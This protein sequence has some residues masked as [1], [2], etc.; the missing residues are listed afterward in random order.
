MERDRA[1]RP[2]RCAR[3]RRG[4]GKERRMPS[5]KGNLLCGWGTALLL[6]F[7]G[8]SAF[9]FMPVDQHQQLHIP[10]PGTERAPQWRTAQMD[11]V[12]HPEAAGFLSRADG[13][14]W[15]QTNAVTG[16]PH[17]VFGSGLDLG[18]GFLSDE[19]AVEDVARAFVA[20]HAAYLGVDPAELRVRSIAHGLGKWG[21]VFDQIH[22]GVEVEGSRLRVL[23]TDEGR[24][25]YFGSDWHPGV[26]VSVQPGLGY[27]VARDLAA[28]P[29]G[30]Q[31]GRDVDE[32]GELRILPVLEE[33]S[34]VYRLVW[35]TRLEIA[36]P[37]AI[38]VSYVDAETGEILWRYNDVHYVDV[39]GTTAGDVEDFG[40]CYSE[41]DRVLPHMEVE[42][43][44]G[45]SG[46]SDENGLFDIPHG[47][48]DDVTV[49]AA[50]DGR[51]INANNQGGADASFSGIA[52][53][54]V[55]F[56]IRFDDGNSQDDERDVYLHGNRIHDLIKHYD[57]DWSP[58]DYRMS[59]NVSINSSCNA[60]WNGSSINFYQAGGGCGNTGQMGDVIYHEYGHGMTQWIYGNNP[61]DVG[62]GNSDIAAIFIDGNSIIGEGFYL[63][64]CSSGIRDADNNLQY[65]DDYQQGQIHFNGQIVAGFWWDAREILLPELGEQGTL[66]LLWPNWHFG[67]RTLQ[68]VSMPDQVL[69]AFLMDDDNGDLTDGTPHYDAFCPA[70]ENH[71]FDPPGPTPVVSIEHQALHNQ[72]DDGQPDVV[73]AT[74]TSSET[75]IDPAAIDLRYQV[76][77]GGIQVVP[78]TPTG[79]PDEYA[80]EIPA[81]PVGSF[82]D[83]SI[84][85]RD[86]DGN[87]G[88]YPP[89]NCDPEEPNGAVRFYV[90]T[91]VDEVES[92]LG[93]VV[94]PDGDD[95]ATTGIWERIDPRGT[96]AQPEDDQTP[97][98]GIYAWIT[99]QC[100]PGCGL[101]DNDI[102]GGKTTLLS[103]LYDLSGA[104]TA[105][106]VY[107]RWYS[108]DTG[109]EPGQD[110]W[111]VDVSNDGGETFTT[112]ENTNE[113]A[114]RWEPV[115]IDLNA[116]FGEPGSV[117]VRYTASDYEPGS[118]VEAGVDEFLLFVDYV[119]DAEEA[120]AEST[121]PLFALRPARPNPTD[122]GSRI[123]F[124][125]PSAAPVR[126]TVHDVGGRL[127]DTLA[128]G[129]RF[130]AGSH[131]LVWNGH[132]RSGQPVAAGVY[133][134]RLQTPGFAASRS[135]VVQR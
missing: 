41:E 3:S 92:D 116:L 96:A 10:M 115:E 50:L 91:F 130:T 70:A 132:D 60:Y 24:L 16:T 121:A 111:V 26:D 129:Q 128:G 94:D 63:D 5:R 78:M 134:I 135:F 59:A 80:G 104:T 117:Q 68:P 11:P 82:L 31:A 114:A 49:N 64:E 86:L 109:A 112:V 95:D 55:P 32:G 133:Y 47:G 29:I 110:F 37:Y 46:Y 13:T 74:I 22:G 8:G 97:P 108:N 124:E 53:P 106:I 100:E 103:P 79:N 65:P 62:E 81:Q 42:V 2:V 90:A 71:G 85:A 17:A 39:V 15:S 76:N 119:T 35:K 25:A 107:Y 73:T 88:V 67:R 99:G 123:V 98:P 45:N 52:T 87:P 126:V 38:W 6:L 66:D 27:V 102:D 1:H 69:A 84:I 18:T 77:A 56:E 118:L 4:I 122:G 40:Y 75:A 43:V 57:P 36:E 7:G 72:I 28:A 19:A 9:G 54:G 12:T 89:S 20:D 21:I 83:Y 127:V 131:Q 105:K 14:W 34:Y 101:G 125:I 44:G 58:P 30:F 51:W 113:S 61:S 93:W 48:G 23:I 33:G 120:P